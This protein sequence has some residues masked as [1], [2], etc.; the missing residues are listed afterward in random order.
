MTTVE[1]ELDFD[2]VTEADI[3]DIKEYLER[4]QYEESNHNLI[5]MFLWLSWYPLFKVKTDHYYLLLGIHEGELFIYMPLCE[6]AY[7]D[8]AILRAKCIFDRYGVPFV[9]SCFTRGPMDRVLELFPEYSACPAP[10]SFDYVYLT[11]KLISFSGK[12][13]QK[14]RNHL[15]AFYNEYK[16][17]YQYESLNQNNVQEC[18]EFMEDWKKDVIED[19]FFEHEKAG[20]KRLLRQYELFQY[21]GGL[22][23]IDGKVKAFAIGSVLSPRMCQENIEKADDSVRGLYQ[24]IMKEM[25]EH[26]FSGYLYCN[27]E[28]DMG[29]ENLRQAKRAY[30]PEMMIEKFKL[31][32]KGEACD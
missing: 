8:E 17:R 3:P 25:L 11:E 1:V 26:E 21:K 15:N 18:L 30:A 24:T 32:R 29:R 23:R 4:C 27:R 12:K 9:L 5:N 13:L 10:E 28:D 31:C 19:D 14:K 22:I 16:D 2:P 6:A 20:V 7:F